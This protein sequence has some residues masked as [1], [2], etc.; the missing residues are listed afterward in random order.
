MY[1]PPQFKNDN[2]ENIYEFVE[3]NG[4]GILI[5]HSDNKLLATHIPLMLGEDAAGNGV[6]LGHISRGNPQWKNFGENDAVLVI[7][8]GAHSYISSS[9]Y[10]HEN[11]P[12]W[13]YIAVHI[14][15]RIKV[16]AGERL[17]TSLTKLVDKY[18]KSSE[19]PVSVGAMSEKMLQKDLKGIVGFEITID[20]IQ[21][22][23]KLSQNRDPKNLANITKELRR[24]GTENAQ[25]VADAMEKYKR[26]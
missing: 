13:N 7:F 6:L 8:Q 18:E 17:L 15:G 21:S 10:D 5:N 1:I 20:E 26:P 14:Y 19:N 22:A 11:V 25:N 9:W 16:V 3:K 4:F 24:I 2:L 23:A 12:T